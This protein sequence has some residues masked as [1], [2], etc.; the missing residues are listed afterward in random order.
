MFS[1]NRDGFTTYL[2]VLG[3][4]LDVLAAAASL[5]ML[6]RLM[7]NG[8]KRNRACG[9]RLLDWHEVFEN[10]RLTEVLGCV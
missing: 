7:T 6:Y 5:P 2:T 3:T 8:T 1:G 9:D 10:E 4:V